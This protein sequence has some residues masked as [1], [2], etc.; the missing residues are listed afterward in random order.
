MIRETAGFLSGYWPCH[1]RITAGNLNAKR[2]EASMCLTTPTFQIALVG[3]YKSLRNTSQLDCAC[4]NEHEEGRSGSTSP[5]SSAFR[6][7]PGA[8]ASRRTGVWWI[9]HAITRALANQARTIRL[10]VHVELLLGGRAL[11]ISEQVHELEDA[12]GR[13]LCRTTQAFIETSAAHC[14]GV[15]AR[16]ATHLESSETS[17]I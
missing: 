9:R 3:P 4:V 16:R 6:C 15:S 13:W 10:R 5:R 17:P 7:C 1:K 2:Q 11:K 14:V 8:L 12:S